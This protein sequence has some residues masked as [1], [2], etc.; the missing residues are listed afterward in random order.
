MSHISSRPVLIFAC[1]GHALYHV[2]VALFLTLVLVL[3]QVWQRPFDELVGLWTWGALLLGLGA[4]LAG[5]LGDRFGEVR[6]MIIYFVGIGTASI[7]CGVSDGPRALEIS[8]ALMG[9]FGAIYHPVGTAWVVKNI[10]QRGRSIAILGICGSIGAAAASLV[11]AFLADWCGWRAAFVVPGVTAAVAGFALARAF[12]SGRVIDRLGDAVPTL[13]PSRRNVF[14]AFVVLAVTMSLTMLLYH[15]FTT[16]LP[17]WINRELSSELGDGLIATG[18]L[19]SLIYLI[20]ATAQFI[21]GHFSDKGRA[22]EIYAF[23]FLLK[24]MALGLA[25][26]VSGWSVLAAAVTIALVFDIAAPVENILIAQYTPRQRRGLAYGI[27]NGI[28]IIAA[29]LGVQLVSILFN[30]QTGFDRL[31]YVLAATA[32]VVLAASLFLPAQNAR[33]VATVP[34]GD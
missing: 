9:L 13:E 34:A 1:I 16:M 17:K 11:A 33:T 31:L 8:L 14:R 22:K 7:M 25:T 10:E 20:G 24:F 28:A 12:V 32:L 15:A 18:A 4:P 23:S 5:W 27:R 2:I 21:G 19:V 3:E 30:E 29:P 26:V 6:M